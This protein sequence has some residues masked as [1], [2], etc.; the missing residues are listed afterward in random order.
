MGAKRTTELSFQKQNE[1]KSK[2]PFYPTLRD[3]RKRIV[4]FESSLVVPICPSGNRNMKMRMNVEQWWNDTKR[5]EA[6]HYCEKNVY[7]CHFVRL[8][9]HMDWSGI[10]S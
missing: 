7:H 9:C 10:Q 2:V 6:K 5:G 8:K 4:F 1:N 3:F